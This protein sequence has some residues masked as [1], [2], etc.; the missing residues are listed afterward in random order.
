[1]QFSGI[2]TILFFGYLL[3]VGGTA[4]AAL[5]VVTPAAIPK[6]D[7]TP[8]QSRIVCIKGK[9]VLDLLNLGGYESQALSFCSSYIKIPPVTLT[10]TTTLTNFIATT[11]TLSTTTTQTLT[12]PDFVVTVT[13]TQ[14][15]ARVKRDAAASPAPAVAISL[16]AWKS[17]IAVIAPVLVSAGCSCIQTK[18]PLATTTTTL[19][20]STTLASP[21][22][23]TIQTLTATFT[24]QPLMTT[25]TALVPFV[26]P[27]SSG[28]Q[29]FTCTYTYVGCRRQ[30]CTTLSSYQIF[31]LGQCILACDE[32]ELGYAGSFDTEATSPGDF[33]CSCCEAESFQVGQT[34]FNTGNIAFQVVKGSCDK[35]AAN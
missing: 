12:L 3:H 27:L 11:T 19:T 32:D 24:P 2:S 34:N 16:S 6:L 35:A 4:A 5:A 15:P 17:S 18:I 28:T 33:P 31:N 25:T 10:A 9:I 13:Q 7:L 23:T 20:Q 30:S 29:T 1:M 26:C 21:T 14:F 8:A 22:V